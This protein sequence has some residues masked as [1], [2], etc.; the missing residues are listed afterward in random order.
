MDGG[1]GAW[2]SWSTWPFCGDEKQH[3]ERNC[4]SPPPFHGGKHCDGPGLQN[5]TNNETCTGITMIIKHKQ[6]PFL[7]D[8]IFI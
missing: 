4:T 3:R 7:K 2:S 5:K 6:Q 8:Y 1:W